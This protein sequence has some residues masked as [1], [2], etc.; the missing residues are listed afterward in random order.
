MNVYHPTRGLKLEPSIWVCSRKRRNAAPF[1]VKLLGQGTAIHTV[2]VHDGTDQGG[3]KVVSVQRNCPPPEVLFK[4]IRAWWLSR[5]VMAAVPHKSFYFVV[6]PCGDRWIVAL[7]AT[8]TANNALAHHMRK[9]GVVLS[10]T[11]PGMWEL[12]GRQLCELFAQ[13]AQGTDKPDRH[14]IDGNAHGVAEYTDLVSGYLA[15]SLK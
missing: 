11:D 10:D 8:S 4:L 15:D 9:H 1:R 13:H 2:K 14:D 5:S 6:E 12:V 3:A 7:C